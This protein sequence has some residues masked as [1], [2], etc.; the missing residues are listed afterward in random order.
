MELHSP[1]IDSLP[2]CREIRL[3]LGDALREVELLRA[4]LKVAER[5]ERY[6]ERDRE[7]LQKEAS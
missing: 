6:R 7:A 4:L 1:V 5:A 3:K 2:P